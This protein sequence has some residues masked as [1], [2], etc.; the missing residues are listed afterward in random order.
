MFY[1]NQESFIAPNLHFFRRHSKDQDTFHNENVIFRHFSKKDSIDLTGAGF[2]F[3]NWILRPSMRSRFFQ[4][5]GFEPQNTGLVAYHVQEKRAI[6]FLSLVEHT[7]WLYSIKFLFTDPNFRK[8]GVAT[9]LLNYAGSLAKKRGARKV[10]L[11]QS[12]EETSTVNLYKKLGFKI[13]VP[14]LGIQCF[15]HV[16]KLS[17]KGTERLT[18][19]KL[20]SKK[21]KNLLY[22]IYQLCMGNKWIDF[23]ETSLNNIGNGYSQDFTRFFSKTAFTNAS[24][25]SIV[26]V[27]IRPLLSNVDVELFSLSDSS[28]QLMLEMLFRFL[29]NAGLKFAKISIFNVKTDTYF[30]M[31][32][33]KGLN[34]WES[35]IVGK[36]I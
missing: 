11:S 20:S 26:I 8:M 23:F 36:T 19:L 35:I 22:N 12:P 16:P 4:T 5:I 13:I 29:N 3:G 32:E 27:Y 28:S 1:L 25:D 10:W 34:P 33:K 14:K 21:D 24:L 17:A 2:T 18:P 6:G 9:G 7:Q 15:G 31:L 30:Q